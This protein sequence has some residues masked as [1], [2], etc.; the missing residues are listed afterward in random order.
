MSSGFSCDASK[1]ATV[2][3]AS[4]AI[5]CKKTMGMSRCTSACTRAP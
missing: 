2:R 4:S 1:M 5:V 3:S